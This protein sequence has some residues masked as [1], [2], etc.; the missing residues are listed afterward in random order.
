MTLFG[1]WG[2]ID[3]RLWLLFAA[4]LADAVIG[5]PDAVWKRLSHPVVL[6]GR[7]G[8]ERIGAEEWARLC[9]TISYE[10]VCDIAPRRRRV[11]HVIV[12]G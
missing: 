8:A 1:A 5:D 11:E 6:I 12:D 9:D 2:A 4:L 7:D 10:I 3:A